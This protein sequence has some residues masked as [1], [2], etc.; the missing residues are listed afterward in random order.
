MKKVNLESVLL[1]NAANRIFGFTL[2]ELLVVIAIIGIL[3]ALLLPAVQAAREAARRSQCTNNLKQIGLACL[4]HENVYK[5][6]PPGSDTN[7]TKNL[8][9]SLFVFI[10]PYM[11]QE[12]LYESI[13]K[14]MNTQGSWVNTACQVV[15]KPL[16]CPSDNNYNEPAKGVT[17]MSNYCGSTGDYC[18]YETYNATWATESSFSRGAFQPNKY[19]TLGA[20]NDGTSNTLLCSE[21]CIGNPATSIKGGVPESVSGAFPNS[22]Y[23]ACESSGFNPSACADRLDATKKAYTG[24]CYGP[25]G[26]ETDLRAMGRWYHASDIFARTNTILPPN[27]A[28]GSSGSNSVVPM[29]L[30]PSSYH[31]GGVN[32][33]RCDGSG[34]FI[35][36]SVNCGTITGGANGLC[37]RSGMSNFGVWGAFGSRDGEEGGGL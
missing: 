23:N 8:N 34:G 6:L 18:C 35:N 27:S 22:N 1:N 13:A 28:S 21:R 33:V 3:I 29:L 16:R 30:P 15:L 7:A 20:I 10:L 5:K 14:N 31:P 32:V 19:T 4:N 24:K 26:T 9:Y 11:E 12:A 37:K 17:V 2:V 36:D 25:T